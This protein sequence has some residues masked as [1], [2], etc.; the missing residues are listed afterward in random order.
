MIA[1]IGHFALLWALAIAILQATVSLVRAKR[2]DA[3]A[4]QSGSYAAMAQFLFFAIWFGCLTHAFVTSD[5][6]AAVVAAN[7]HSLQPMLYKATGGSLALYAIRMPQLK[8]GSPFSI[9]SRKAGLTLNNV[10]LTVAC[11][12]VFLGTL[13]PLIVDLLG[14]DK[15]SVGSPFCAITFVPIMIALPIAMA[16]GPMLKWKRD[17]LPNRP[18]KIEASSDR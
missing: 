6:S 5:F 10:I 17:E 13:Y 2:H 18:S 16:V 7:S 3:W 11:A 15:I 4:M 14:H 12:T 1:E 9:V 8:A